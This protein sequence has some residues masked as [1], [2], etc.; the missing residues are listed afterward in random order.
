MVMSGDGECGT[1]SAFFCVNGKMLKGG[2]CVLL[3]ALVCVGVSTHPLLKVVEKTK[4]VIRFSCLIL[5]RFQPLV[6]SMSFFLSLEIQSREVGF[7]GVT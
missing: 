1:S 6:I 4:S 7:W 2:E 3:T 5:G